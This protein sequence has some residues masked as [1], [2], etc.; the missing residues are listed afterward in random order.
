MAGTRYGG[1]TRGTRNG[2]RT[3]LSAR[4]SAAKARKGSFLVRHYAPKARAPLTT[5]TG[6]PTPH[7]KGAARWGEP[8]PKTKSAEARLYA[9]GKRMLASVKAAGK[10]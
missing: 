7:A 3:V 1:K 6:K 4:T 9:K 5:K 8:V 2:R 10:K